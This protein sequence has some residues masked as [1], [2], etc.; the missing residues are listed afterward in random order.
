MISY[1]FAWFSIPQKSS[2]NHPFARKKKENLPKPWIFIVLGNFS[3]FFSAK[4]W[5]FDVFF[6][7]FLQFCLIF[8]L[9]K[10][11]KKSSK[12]HPFARKNQENLPKPQIFTVF[13]KF[14]WF[15]LAKWWFFDDFLGCCLIFSPSKIITKSSKNHPFTRKNKENLPK[16]W[17]FIVFGK[18][19]WFVL[20]KWWFF[21]DFWMI[22]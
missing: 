1:C 17:F 21:D 11:M 14:S 16:L 8:F 3:W 10:I 22:S 20:A 2:K 13:G 18:F 7:D 6:D 19:S 9:S 5:F 4:L 12:K 15:V